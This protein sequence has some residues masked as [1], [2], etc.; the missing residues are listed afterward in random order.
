MEQLVAELRGL[1]NVRAANRAQGSVRSGVVR[2]ATVHVLFNGS[3]DIKEVRRV[4]LS[5]DLHVD[6]KP[7]GIG[8]HALRPRAS[9]FTMHFK[10]PKGKPELLIFKRSQS[11]QLSPDER[12]KIVAFVQGLRYSLN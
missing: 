8:I 5:N 11:G 6:Q 7:I 10:C 4:A 9:S 12:R 1:S 2:P 3:F